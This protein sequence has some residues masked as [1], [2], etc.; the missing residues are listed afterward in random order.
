MK[1]DRFIWEIYDKFNYLQNMK[2]MLQLI[3]LKISIVIYS[4][5]KN[6]QIYQMLCNT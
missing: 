3:Q 6:P 4:A 2:A 5:Y 1:G